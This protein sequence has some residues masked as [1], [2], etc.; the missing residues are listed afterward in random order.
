MRFR[1]AV[2][3]CRYGQEQAIDRLYQISIEKYSNR[4]C[5]TKPCTCSSTIDSCD[6]RF[7]RVIKLEDHFVEC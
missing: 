6:H 1:M 7:V 3:F 2:G 4:A 5:K